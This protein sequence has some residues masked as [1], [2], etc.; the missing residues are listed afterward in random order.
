MHARGAHA[1]PAGRATAAPGFPRPTCPSRCRRGRC[2][3][4]G[5]GRC[6][7]RTRVRQPDSAVSRPRTPRAGR[8]SSSRRPWD[9]RRRSGRRSR[10]RGR[11]RLR[12][13]TAPAS[14]RRWCPSRS[15]DT[16]RP[17]H[18]FLGR[19]GF[20][21]RRRHVGLQRNRR[22]GRS[23]L[24]GDR[25][26]TRAG[27]LIASVFSGRSLRTRGPC[28]PP[29]GSPGRRYRSGARWRSRRVGGPASAR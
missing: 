20:A 4:P 12:A 8:S 6:C 16:T 13:S 11:R 19:N 3:S 21:P 15:R 25:S 27:R 5:W 10:C 1:E 26:A 17:S 14:R 28:T 23:A 29:P 2:R 18:D 24:A 7:A 22:C 9:C